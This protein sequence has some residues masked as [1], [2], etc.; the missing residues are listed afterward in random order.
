MVA[1]CESVT[2][3]RSEAHLASCHL[4]GLR[5]VGPCPAEGG[6]DVAGG[7][8]PAPPW[9]STRIGNGLSFAGE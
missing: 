7:D 6:A 9:Q 2:F 4:R 3:F 8:V 5:G 1:V